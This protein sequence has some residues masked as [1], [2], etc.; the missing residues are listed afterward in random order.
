MISIGRRWA[1]TTARPNLVNILPK[2][3][4]INRLLYD[5]DSRLAYKKVMIVLNSIYGNLDKP[6]Q[7]RLPKFATH[8]DLMMIRSILHDIRTVS[9]AVN[10]DL[11]DLENEL[12]EQAAELG[13][14]DAIAMLAFEA[15]QLKQTSKEDAKHAGELIRQLSDLKHP[16]VFKLA[17]DLAL[18]KKLYDQ[19][20]EYWTQFL[21]LENDTILASHVYSNLGIYY[22]Q[23]TSPRPDLN[24]AKLCFDKA[25]KFGELD[26]HTVKAHYY[27]G[28][29]YT[30]TD[31]E[32]SRY[33]LQLSAS[34]GLQ[35]SFPSL[36]F[37]ELN[38]FDD[39]PQA[40][41]WFRLGVESNSD[42]SCLVGQFDAHVRTGNTT[43][44]LLILSNL[45]GVKA[46]LD[47]VMKMHELKLPEKFQEMASSNAT[48]L[49]IF[50][51][52]RKSEIAKLRA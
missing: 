39:V 41:Q 47:K 3:K 17:G 2:K 45:E 22:Y 18:S 48:L 49:D 10:R 26:S 42:L 13:N 4:T 34:R 11:V 29:L 16:L 51:Q 50:F 25:I 15:I 46:K 31:P 12:V 6:D 36:G 38:V 32:L 9:K 21:E 30:I 37:L 43:S 1:L 5:N 44:A 24:K 14:N 35:E 40:L 52:T 23:H 28:Q 33:H 7:I 8:A 27:L 20:A 19:A